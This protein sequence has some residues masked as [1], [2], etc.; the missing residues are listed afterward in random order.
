MDWADLT[1]K[2]AIDESGQD[3]SATSGTES[4][5]KTAKKE[6]NGDKEEVKVD[7]EA[8]KME[9][10]EKDAKK[11][12]KEETKEETKEGKGDEKELKNDNIFEKL[13]KGKA[14]NESSV[15]IEIT[16]TTIEKKTEIAGKKTE[17]T[18]KKSESSETEKAKPAAIKQRVTSSEKI[19][20][21]ESS[22]CNHCRFLSIRFTQSIHKSIGDNYLIFLNWSFLR[23]RKRTF[24]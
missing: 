15:H 18:E 14:D 24:Q 1:V 4:P 6:T 21:G 9:K 3:E 10:E 17:I 20:K 2:D 22:C 23:K 12:S 11:E 5:S 7:K 13:T 8:T 19:E 16:A